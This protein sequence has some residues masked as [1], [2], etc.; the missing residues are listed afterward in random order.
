MSKAKTHLD[1]SPKEDAIARERALTTKTLAQCYLDAGYSSKVKIPRVRA[2]EVLNKPHVQERIDYYKS[3]AAAKLD[4]RT[5]RIMAEF[6]AIAFADPLDVFDIDD[7]GF[8][9]IKSLD[10]MAPWARR[11]IMSIKTKR[12]I[13]DGAG[14]KD[15]TILDE[16]IEVKF[17]P[18]VAALTKIAEIKNMFKE[19]EKNRT[20]KVNIDI[21]FQGAR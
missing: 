2:A 1:C 19:H 13:L 10:G 7:G 6:A 14:E 18:K 21:S 3:M 20:P 15:E 5:E 8:L 11:S 9:Q 17:H 4:I 12:R 16:E